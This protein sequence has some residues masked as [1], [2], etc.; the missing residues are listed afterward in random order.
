M[1]KKLTLLVL[2]STTIIGHTNTEK[3]AEEL[4]Q[5]KHQENI[6]YKQ[7]MELLGTGLSLIQEGIIRENHSMVAVGTDFVLKGQ[8]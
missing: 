3:I 5:S 2:L 4:V 6:N 1:L 7:L 8:P